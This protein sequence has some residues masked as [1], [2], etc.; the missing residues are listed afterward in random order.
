MIKEEKE[1]NQK[2]IIKFWPYMEKD[3]KSLT[4][5]NIKILDTEWL[6]QESQKDKAYNQDKV[7]QI[8]PNIEDDSG[9]ILSHILSWTVSEKQQNMSSARQTL[10][11]TKV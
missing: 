2:S 4:A 8:L 11:D 1:F 6:H 9:Q 7:T 3:R 5:P 10:M